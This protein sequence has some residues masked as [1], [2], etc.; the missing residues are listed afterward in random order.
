MG[1]ADKSDSQLCEKVHATTL[2]SDLGLLK[3][4]FTCKLGSWYAVYFKNYFRHEYC[5]VRATNGFNSL[6]ISG[7]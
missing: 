2:L 7:I 5:A 4:I 1:S 6:V 3:G